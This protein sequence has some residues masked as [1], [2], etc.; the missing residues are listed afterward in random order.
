MVYSFVEYA[1]PAVQLPVLLIMDNFV[2]HLDN[3]GLEYLHDHNVHLLGLPPHI[4][5][6]TQPLDLTVFGPLKTA[7]RNEF[8]K[9]LQKYAINKLHQW[10]LIFFL[11]IAYKK[12]LTRK[13]ISS[14]F[15]KAGLIPFNSLVVLEC[16]EDWNEELHISFVPNFDHSERPLN[17]F[18][19]ETYMENVQ[20]IL[21]EA[22]QGNSYSPRL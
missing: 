20:E 19:S 22:T 14:G 8:D 11:N 1:K 15:C 17:E 16:C 3:A 9:A 2:G 10:D 12:A 5:D 21:E 6:K 13:N 7:Y 18:A 4:S